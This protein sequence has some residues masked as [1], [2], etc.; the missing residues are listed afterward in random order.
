MQYIQSKLIVVVSLQLKQTSKNSSPKLPLFCTNLQSW[1]LKRFARD[2][3]TPTHA[4]DW[5]TD[6]Y[7]GRF[8]SG[9]GR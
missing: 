9:I 2:A 8:D 4:G 3:I 5:P 6:R 1:Q 7:C